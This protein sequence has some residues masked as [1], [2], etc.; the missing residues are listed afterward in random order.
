VA[1]A[2]VN[3]QFVGRIVYADDVIILSCTI[4][5]LQSM[6]S[7]C[8]IVRNQPVLLLV[9]GGRTPSQKCN[10]VHILL[11]GVSRLNTLVL[12]CSHTDVI[13]RKFLLVVIQF[14]IILLVR[15]S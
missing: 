6:L 10:L 4:S 8:L 9:P 1:M 5:G 3:Y 11:I 7:V 14:L 12:P 2:I 13:K 15:M